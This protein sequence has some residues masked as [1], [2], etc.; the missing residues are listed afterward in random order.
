MYKALHVRYSFF[1]SDFNKTRIFLEDFQKN[2]Q[3]SYFMKIQ[4]VGAELFHA[5]GQTH[6]EANSRFSQF[7]KRA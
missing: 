2:T 6:D 4:P 1:L 3:I 5:D 7:S